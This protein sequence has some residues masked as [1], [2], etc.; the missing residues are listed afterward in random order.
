[1]TV[2]PS[3]TGLQPDW[4]LLDVFAEVCDSALIENSGNCD[5]VWSSNLQLR[6]PT[7]LLT[8]GG[9]IAERSVCLINLGKWHAFQWKIITLY[10][11][12]I[13]CNEA[14]GNYGRCAWWDTKL[15]KHLFQPTETIEIEFQRLHPHFRGR[16]TQWHK[17]CFVH[18]QSVGRRTKFLEMQQQHNMTY[19]PTTYPR[20][21]YVPYRDR[22]FGFPTSSCRFTW[23][24]PL[25]FRT[26][27][28]CVQL[29]EFRFYCF[30]KLTWMYSRERGRQIGFLVHDMVVSLICLHVTHSCS[31]KSVKDIH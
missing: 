13:G 1:M 19:R 10:W 22:Q 17:V 15:E 25:S 12:I 9:D 28:I 14:Y 23:Q 31:R 11:M 27:K 29:S 30:I 3:M 8:V 5:D 26:S 2:G 24:H 20:D 21:I 18:C 16:G 4:R 6:P 7:N